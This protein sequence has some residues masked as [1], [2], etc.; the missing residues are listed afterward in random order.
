ML[1]C[2]N[3]GKEEPAGSRFCGSCGAPFAPAE[4]ESHRT[5]SMEAATPAAVTSPAGV[6]ATTEVAQPPVSSQAPP[7]R[8][9]PPSAAAPPA[10]SRRRL[11]RFVLI[12]ALVPVVAGGVL[13]ATGVIGG[14]S[15]KSKSAFVLQVNENALGPLGRADETAAEHAST[16]DGA[17]ARSEDASR[18]VR[19][20]DEASAYLGSLSG[21]SGEQKGQVQVLLAFVAAN[22][23]YGQALAAF[24]PTNNQAQLAL[25]GAAAAAR[26]VIATGSL[27]ADL[28]L[29]SQTAFISSPSV[30]PLPKKSTPAATEPAPEVPRA[31]VQQV[32]RLLRE[33]HA[34][35]LALSSFVSRAASNAIG[36]NEAVALARSFAAKRRSE[37]VDTQAL[38][39]PP[40]FAPAHG[41]LIR[42]L[43]ASLADDR[44]LVAWTVARRDGSGE[45]QAAFDRANRIG[46]QASALKRQFL[47][48]YGQ[49][50]QSATG[51]TSAT[52]PDT[53]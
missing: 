35:V 6:D 43:Q 10:G 14:S 5:D 25:E 45:A 31:Y 28:R 33:S 19:I 3:C 40:T 4:P 7:S 29:P 37:L 18:I 34:V 27:P 24:A 11:W 41:L 39:V 52:L 38:I 32:D 42:A 15:G 51:L 1:T 12:A 44:A 13:F 23:R 50:R 22:R 30:S 53:F 49:Q 21:L 47:R 26:A 2:T 17:S 20:A 9:A 46:A 48:V 16:A 8:P 36:R